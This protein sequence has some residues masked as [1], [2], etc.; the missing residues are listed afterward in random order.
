MER[1]VTSKSMARRVSPRLAAFLASRSQNVC[2]QCKYRAASAILSRHAALISPFVIRRHASDSVKDKVLSRLW[3][4]S[5]KDTSDSSHKG[6]TG[7]ESAELETQ[8]NEGE[9]EAGYEFHKQDAGAEYM[10]ALTTDGL[11]TIGEITQEIR[12]KRLG[13][14]DG[15]RG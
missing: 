1:V 11:S 2:L 5:S 14:R 6:S 9:Q 13:L 12:A 10:E 15:Y 8:L 4:R 3:G 7:E